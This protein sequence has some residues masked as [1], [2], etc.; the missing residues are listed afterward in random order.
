M[1]IVNDLFTIF[2]IFVVKKNYCV[3]KTVQIYTRKVSNRTNFLCKALNKDREKK[4]N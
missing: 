3:K 2:N 4:E 1:I